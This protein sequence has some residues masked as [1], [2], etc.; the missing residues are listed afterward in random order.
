MRPVQQHQVHIPFESVSRQ[1]V[2]GL[3]LDEDH[4][5]GS[6]V[7]LFSQFA[8]R[9]VLTFDREGDVVLARMR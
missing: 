7:A 1:S 4:I 2:F 3:A 8:N 6:K 5:P 9:V